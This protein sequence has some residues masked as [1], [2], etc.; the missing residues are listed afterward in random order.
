MPEIGGAE[1]NIIAI[2]LCSASAERDG[3]ALIL[4]NKL[5]GYFRLLFRT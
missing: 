5:R 4:R 3:N 1:D 2:L